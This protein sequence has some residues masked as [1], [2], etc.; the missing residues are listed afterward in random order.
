MT[1]PDRLHYL[2]HMGVTVW[3]A[4]RGVADT[5]ELEPESAPP[6][7]DVAVVPTVAIK[8]EVADSWTTLQREVATCRA[9]TLHQ[10]RTQT[11]F[12]VGNQQARWLIVGEAP[13]AE[14]DMQG[15]PFVGRAGQLL[16][17]MLFAMGHPR[18][19]VYIA[20]TVKCRPP[21]NREPYADEAAACAHF[22]RRQIALL[23]PHIILCVG[24]VA[25]NNVLGMQ[26]NMA[27]F[28]RRVHRYA[29]TNIPVIVTYH[30]A[31][32][33]RAPSDK[34]KAWE[35]LQFAVATLNAESRAR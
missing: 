27:A 2:H 13:G 6:P 4:R 7:T 25:A 19:T 30:P 9:C 8:P 32:L 1:A 33:L 23:Q 29:D 34:R 18:D 11:V 24:R 14:E 22:L 20:N 15:E 3:R 35:D 5:S 28:R 21:N 26:P 10:G 17:E 31:Y 12:G 16:N